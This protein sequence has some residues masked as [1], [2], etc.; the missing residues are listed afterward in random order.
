[1]NEGLPAS[2]AGDMVLQFLLVLFVCMSDLPMVVCFIIPCVVIIILQ[3]LPVFLFTF[4]FL[5]SISGF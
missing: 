4:F 3:T 2:R 5:S 1:M